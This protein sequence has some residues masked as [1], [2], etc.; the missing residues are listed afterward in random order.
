MIFESA[1]NGVCLDKGGPCWESMHSGRAESIQK[2]IQKNNICALRRSMSCCLSRRSQ[3]KYPGPSPAPMLRRFSWKPN[4]NSP[5]PHYLNYL[6]VPLTLFTLPSIPYLHYLHYLDERPALFALFRIL[7]LGA[8][9][10][11]WQKCIVCGLVLRSESTLIVHVGT[12]LWTWG[13]YFFSLPGDR[14]VLLR[15]H[16]HLTWINSAWIKYGPK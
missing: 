10:E 5:G 8:T 4:W 15:N 7:T 3:P 13:C 16:H 12:G 9:C 6:R 14:C 11:I 1:P 2:A